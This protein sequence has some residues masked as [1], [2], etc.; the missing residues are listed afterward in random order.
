MDGEIQQ[1]CSTFQDNFFFNK[2]ELDDM[3]RLAQN[4]N[5]EVTKI[6]Q[7]KDNIRYLY[8]PNWDYEDIFHYMIE[9]K[10]AKN[11]ELSKICILSSKVEDLRELDF[12]MRR[13]YGIYSERVFET[14]EQYDKIYESE[15][16]PNTRQIKLHGLRRTRKFNFKINSELIKLCTVHSFKGWESNT[17]FVILDKEESESKDEILYTA[18]TRCKNNLVII[19]RNDVR[20]DEFFR[21]VI[22]EEP[23]FHET[24]FFTKQE[25]EYEEDYYYES[26]YED[27]EG[28]IYCAEDGKYHDIEDAWMY[29]GS[30]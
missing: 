8:R 10:N 7:S 19:N 12:M 29:D 25:V 22:D 16:N 23:I 13:K 1:L 14:K 9:Y 27:N 17:L 24:P 3:N 21:T 4:H 28:K 6:N 20:Y 5:N 2:Y 26:F 18:L 15:A 11:I 30:C